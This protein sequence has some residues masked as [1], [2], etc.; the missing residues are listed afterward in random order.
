MTLIQTIIAYI[1][2]GIGKP[3]NDWFNSLHSKP[4]SLD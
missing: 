3:F 2:I 4:P 1:G